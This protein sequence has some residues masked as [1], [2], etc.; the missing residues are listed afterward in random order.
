[1]SEETDDRPEDAP[2]PELV[3]LAG[4]GRR[5]SILRPILMIAVIAL[6]AWIISDWRAEL[7]YFFSSSDPVE[8]GS[9]TDFAIKKAEDPDWTPPIP[10]NRYVRLEGIPTQRSQSARY[11]FFGLVGASIFIEEERD[12]YIEDPMERELEGDAKGDVDRTVYRGAGRALKFSEIP[13]RYHGL[14]HYYASRYNIVFCES[15]DP[16]GYRELEQ[17]KR[18]A[19]VAQWRADYKDASPEEREREGLTLEPSPDEIAEIMSTDP[20]C[21]EAWLI[22]DGVEPSEHWWYVAAAAMF[23]LF[24]LFNVVLLVR[25]VRDFMR[26]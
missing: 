1:M 14:R 17:R 22:Q 5:P 2:D 9:A 16:R 13:Q 20:V 8:L 25:W 12:D 3:A 21:V 11:R 23:G 6:G 10:H 7:E 19:I 26:S 24:M 4:T 15:L 18:D